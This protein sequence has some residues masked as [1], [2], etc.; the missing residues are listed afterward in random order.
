MPC[1]YDICQWGRRKKSLWREF[2]FPIMKLFTFPK[3]LR[4]SQKGKR[5]KNKTPKRKTTKPLKHLI[6]RGEEI[7]QPLTAKYEMSKCLC[8]KSGPSRGR[9]LIA[10]TW[11]LGLWTGCRLP[12]KARVSALKDNDFLVKT[13]RGEGVTGPPGEVGMPLEGRLYDSAKK[14][15]LREQEPEAA[16]Q[17]CDWMIEALIA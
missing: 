1:V 7:A 16:G 2:L 6:W 14:G 10:D 9:M 3:L 5:K 15:R 12:L 11:P 13:R 8:Q 4:T 17:F